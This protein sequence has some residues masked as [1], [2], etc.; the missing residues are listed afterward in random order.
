M[1]LVELST[2][3]REF[4]EQAALVVIVY[5]FCERSNFH[6]VRLRPAPSDMRHAET[7]PGRQTCWL[8]LARQSCETGPSD[9]AV[10]DRESVPLC[11]VAGARW[12]NSNS[13]SRARLKVVCDTCTYL[14][15]TTTI[16]S[17]RRN[18]LAFVM[19]LCA[20][21]LEIVCYKED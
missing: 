20:H 11:T 18:F 5:N 15:W 17:N 14:V 3:P 19:S 21:R 13:S 7:C 4:R 8:V 9:R 2:L 1:I 12:R 10:G 6:T 16:R